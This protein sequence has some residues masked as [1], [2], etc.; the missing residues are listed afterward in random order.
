MSCFAGKKSRSLLPY[1][2]N[3]AF[4]SKA[5]CG[6]MKGIVL[7]GGLG[8]RLYPLTLAASKQLHAVFDKPM[9]Y[10]P[11]ATLMENGIREICLICTKNDISRFEDLLGDGKQWGIALEYRI[12]NR[13]A[14]IA[15]A[16]IIARDFIGK[17]SVCLIL[18]DNIF[19]PARAFE[20]AF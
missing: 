13:A 15:E 6:V 20:T 19:H 17:A 14:G 4:E 12:Q 10:Y 9:V 11:L 3:V 5:C 16:F 1:P 18:G 8:S 2:F 7:A